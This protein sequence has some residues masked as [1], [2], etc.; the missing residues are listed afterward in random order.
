ML[1]IGWPELLLIMV[2]TVLVVGPRELPNV[3]RTITGLM[4]KMRM[5][6]QELRHNIDQMTDQGELRSIKREITNLQGLKNNPGAELERRISAVADEPLGEDLQALKKS[7]E[8]IRDAAR[9]ITQAGDA[10]KSDS[11]TAARNDLADGNLADGNLA[12]AE[13]SKPLHR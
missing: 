10:A 13:P 4:R 11:N 9:N 1:D 7:G 2:I 6:T 12:P 5:L 3:I 8:E